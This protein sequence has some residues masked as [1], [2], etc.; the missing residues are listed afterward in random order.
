MAGFLERVL[1]KSRNNQNKQPGFLVGWALGHNVADIVTLMEDGRVRDNGAWKYSPQENSEKNT[2]EIQSVLAKMKNT[3]PKVQ[4]CSACEHGI[5]VNLCRK[6]TV[7]RRQTILP[8]LVTDSLWTVKFGADGKVLKR[9]D[10]D[11]AID[12]R[13]P[14]RVR[15]THKQPDKPADSDK[16]DG[17][18][19][20]RCTVG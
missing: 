10:T 17:K 14:K 15:F 6:H 13:D 9:H 4:G 18:V 8:S 12:S 3:K 19:T 1:V 11:D 2:R 20:K 16:T 5:S 7:Q